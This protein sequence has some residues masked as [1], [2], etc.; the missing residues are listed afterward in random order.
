MKD[1]IIEIMWKSIYM[2]IDGEYRINESYADDIESLFTEKKETICP[3]CGKTMKGVKLI[4]YRCKK[5][6][7]NFTD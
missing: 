1:K 3:L 5:C 2:D 6:E 7:V 4:H